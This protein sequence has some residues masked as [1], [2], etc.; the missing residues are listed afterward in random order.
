MRTGLDLDSRR[1]VICLG[2][3]G[4]GK[5][6][7]SAAI[8]LAE[9]IRGRRVDVMTIDPAPRL[10]DALGLEADAVELQSVGLAGLR[11]KSS[12]RLRALRLDPKTTF[13]GLIARHAPSPAARDAIIAGRIYQN[14]SSALAG[15]ADY[16]A[17]ERLLGLYHEGGAELIVLDTPPA[18]EALDFL[19]A[20]Q[21]M[22]DLMSSRAITLLGASRGLMR[23]PLSVLDLA[24][25]AVLS[26]FDRLTG[27]HLLADVQGFVRGFEGMYDGFATRAA[28]A[29][30]L[31]RADESFIVLVTS[32]SPERVDEAREFART[33]RAMGLRI[34]AVAVNRRMASLPDADEIETAKLPVGL[35]AK[36]RRNLAD[37]AALKER[38]RAA[39]ARLRA[40]IPDEI[41]I[42][43]ADDLGREPRAL[44]DLAAIA[45]GLHE[46]GSSRR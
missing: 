6:T 23:A 39:L 18:R 36:L 16:M 2:P 30:A 40:A 7:F 27:L 20:P 3:G 8:A 21:R 4:V 9:A 10:L 26:A 14:L 25:R 32:P 15:V 1:L 13:D 11:A 19:E 45:A 22:L 46:L 24:A 31:I 28:E 44:A 12:G 43:V 37:F 38:E 29:A 35:K 42:I 34:G 41:P 5:T 33:L 17:M